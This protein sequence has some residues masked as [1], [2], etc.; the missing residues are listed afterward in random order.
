[1]SS[2]NVKCAACHKWIHT[3][4]GKIKKIT[5]ADEINNFSRNIRNLLNINDIICGNCRTQQFSVTLN[6]N[7]ND[8]HEVEYVELPISRTVS[9]HKYCCVCNCEDNLT[10]VPEEA[11]LQTYLKRKIYIPTSNRCCRSHLI[12]KRFYDED[13]NRLQVFSNYSSLTTDEIQKILNNVTSECTATVLDKC[14]NHGLS[15]DQIKIF[16][17]LS[18]DNISELRSMMVS[19]RKSSSRTVCDNINN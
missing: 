11:Q 18:W 13:L 15:E 2:K 12:K 19:M 10:Q 6:E 3:V 1:M 14:E 4:P 7:S 16:T 17:G 5:N 8:I 9:T